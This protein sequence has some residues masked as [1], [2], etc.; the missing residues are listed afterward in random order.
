MKRLVTCL[1]A[2]LLVIGAQSLMAQSTNTTPSTPGEH[3]DAGK[4][5]QHGELLKM[6]DLTPADLKGL[7]KEERQTKMKD[8]A[9]KVIADLE[10]KKSAGTL[11]E[12]GQKRLERVQHWLD[13]A[14][15]EATKPPQNN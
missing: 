10:A 11:D 15:G 3:Q 6:L 9:E 14:N 5:H 2:G 1:I 8:A 12:H 13:H 4:H 7:S